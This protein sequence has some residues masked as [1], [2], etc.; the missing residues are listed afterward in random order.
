MR[1]RRD[2]ARFLADRSLPMNAPQPSPGTRLMMILSSDA[3]A[4]TED[5][6][7][8]L[9]KGDVAAVIWRG[10]PPADHVAALQQR[11]VAVLAESAPQGVATAGLDGAH[12]TGLGDLKSALSALKP[13]RI[14]GVGG[15]A[16]RHDAMTAGESGA[17]YLLFGALDGDPRDFPRTLDLLGWWVDLFEVPSVG[18]AG[19]LDEVE[20]IAR[21]GADFVALAPAL[22]AGPQGPAH[23]AQ[24]QALLDAARA[25]EASS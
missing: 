2:F 8:C 11:D 3:A 25:T 24:A 22:V 18:V 20:A 10:A 16:S 23:V 1:P 7:A 9:E 19:T 5:L 6:I 14:V 15:L 21:T 13:D 4:R 17:D 12:V